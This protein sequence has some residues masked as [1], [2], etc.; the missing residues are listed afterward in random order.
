[1]YG[2][3][4][5][6]PASENHPMRHEISYVLAKAVSEKCLD[7]FFRFYKIKYIELRY[8]NVYGPRQNPHG[9]AGVVAIFCSRILDGK[10]FTIFG[11][12]SQT[13]DYVFDEDDFVAKTL[14][15]EKRVMGGFNAVGGIETDINQLAKA[16]LAASPR[17]VD[18]IHAAPR[19]GEQKRSVI[20]A[21]RLTAA[22]GWKPSVSVEEGLARTF[23][24]FAEQKRS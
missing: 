17:P 3:Q 4:E 22:T 7:W 12:G 18:V 13:R 2:E 6:F 10:S 9:E 19:L 14:T 15:L 11:D 21:A 1:M 8:G 24:C 23:R 16:L 5:T 20:S